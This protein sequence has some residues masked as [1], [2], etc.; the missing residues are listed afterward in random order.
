M[1]S[2]INTDNENNASRM[3]KIA[4]NFWKRRAVNESQLKK[5]LTYIKNQSMVGK[6]EN[7]FKIIVLDVNGDT[8]TPSEYI[9]VPFVN[10]VDE[11]LKKLGYKVD[12]TDGIIKVNWA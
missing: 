10:Y 8:Q 9:Y 5:T 3:K 1:P 2:L 6:Y 11:E 12:K 7:E 4:D